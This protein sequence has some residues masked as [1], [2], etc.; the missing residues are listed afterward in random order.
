MEIR[1]LRVHEVWVEQASEIDA[2]YYAS[3]VFD[4]GAQATRVMLSTRGG[5]DSEAVAAQTPDAIASLHVD[6]LLGFQEHHGRR[7]A[8]AA[9]VSR[10]LVAP[11]TAMLAARYE[12]YVEADAVLV[13]V[14]PLIVTGS[15]GDAGGQRGLRALDAKVMLDGNALYR[16]SENAALRDLSAEDPQERL[17]AERGLTYVKA[18]RGD[19]RAR[20]RGGP[21][22]RPTA[23]TPWRRCA[24]APGQVAL[25]PVRAVCRLLSVRRG[26]LLRVRHRRAPGWCCRRCRGRPASRW[27][28]GC[29]DRCTDTSPS[30]SGEGGRWRT[31]TA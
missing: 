28:T 13:E 6:P 24:H 10:D 16:H 14:N 5:M 11:V 9:G 1:G 18:R 22:D 4:R 19:R 27:L 26:L 2:E 25:D 21:G 17:A 8:C 12:T 31:R 29:P 3:I 7:L 30:S 15:A 20:Q 23:T